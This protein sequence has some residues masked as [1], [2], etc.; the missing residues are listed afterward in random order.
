[1]L[2]YSPSGALSPY[3]YKGGYFHGIH[4][5]SYFDNASGLFEMIDKETAFILKS[6]QQKRIMIDLYETTLTDAVVNR[7]VHHLKEI[8]PRVIKL[9]ISAKNKDMKILR[10]A[11]EKNNILHG[12][13]CYGE[14]MEEV[15]TWLVK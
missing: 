13:V 3:H 4:Y 9:G 11:I 15:K 12:C 1:M 10:K 6:P 7:L 14:D 5:G 8:E 2:T